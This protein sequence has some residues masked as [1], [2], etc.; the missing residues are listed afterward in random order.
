MVHRHGSGQPIELA[1][2][3]PRC[4]WCGSQVALGP[5]AQL[6]IFSTYRGN[7]DSGAMTMLPDGAPCWWC[8]RCSH[9]GALLVAPQNV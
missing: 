5:V 1:A 7:V 8:T 2:E 4:P 3:R 9:G 6:R